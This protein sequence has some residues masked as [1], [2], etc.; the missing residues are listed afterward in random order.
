VLPG[1]A[2]Q[3]RALFRRSR[4]ELLDF[5]KMQPWLVQMHIVLRQDNIIFSYFEAFDSILL[6]GVA[7]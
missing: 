6:A 3:E 4:D 7:L 2:P 5:N 1:V